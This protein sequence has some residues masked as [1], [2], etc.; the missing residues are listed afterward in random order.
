MNFCFKEIPTRQSRY[1]VEADLVLSLR[2]KLTGLCKCYIVNLVFLDFV[3][4]HVSLL[5]SP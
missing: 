4:D 3:A 1:L 5:F 2:P